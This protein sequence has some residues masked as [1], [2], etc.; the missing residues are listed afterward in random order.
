LVVVSLHYAGIKA[1]DRRNYSRH[2][3][4]DGLQQELMDHCGLPVSENAWQP[5][6]IALMQWD[7]MPAPSHVGILADHPFGGLSIIHSFSMV[8]VTEHRIDEVW[9]KRIISVF[10]P[11]N[12]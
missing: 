3:W 12:G 4:K 2:P 6:D 5:G 8:A 1:M 7:N 10:N 9:K 11:C